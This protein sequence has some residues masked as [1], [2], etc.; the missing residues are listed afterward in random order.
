[1]NHLI[2]KLKFDVLQLV[3]ELKLNGVSDWLEIKQRLTNFIKTGSE[4]AA[5][6]IEIKPVSAIR[7]TDVIDSFLTA[8]SAEYKPETARKYK[9]LQSVLSEFEKFRTKDILIS[10]FPF[11]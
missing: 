3:R 8:K 4:I 2:E 5:T 9:V 11:R 6:T 1:M 7:L 10:E